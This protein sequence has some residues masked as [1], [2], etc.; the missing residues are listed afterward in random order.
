MVRV[1]FIPSLGLGGSGRKALS[2]GGFGLLRLVLRVRCVCS[3]FRVYACFELS[4]G[5]GV[6]GLACPKP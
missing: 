1:A 6:Q 2:V 5:L 4:L 3:G